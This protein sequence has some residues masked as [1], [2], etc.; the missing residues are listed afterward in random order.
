MTIKL[1]VYSLD[2]LLLT[3]FALSDNCIDLTEVLYSEIS[4]VNCVTVNNADPNVGL[5]E[6]H[7]IICAIANH[8]NLSDS[9]AK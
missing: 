3:C 5:P 8:C 1:I 2:N 4:T 7:Q 9:S 6:S